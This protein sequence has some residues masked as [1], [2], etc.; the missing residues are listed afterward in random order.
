MVSFSAFSFSVF[1]ILVRCVC[2]YNGGLKIG[3]Y[4]IAIENTYK[5]VK[6]MI[7]ANQ[8]T[9]IRYFTK[10]FLHIPAGRWQSVDS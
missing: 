7:L 10:I 5:R 3:F 4:S 1:D 9:K 8:S 2:D 6:L